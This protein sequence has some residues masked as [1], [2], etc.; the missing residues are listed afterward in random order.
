[1]RVRA[2]HTTERDTIDFLADALAG[3]QKIEGD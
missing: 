2:S 1:M 3:Q